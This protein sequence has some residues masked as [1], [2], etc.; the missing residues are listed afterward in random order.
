MKESKAPN[1]ALVA[2][3]FIILLGLA[4]IALYVAWLPFVPWWQEQVAR[5]T[6]IALAWTGVHARLIT[7]PFVGLSVQGKSIEISFVCLGIVEW[8]LLVSAILASRGFEWK[9]RAKGIVYGTVALFAFNEFR[10][11]FTIHTIL[12][13][14]IEFSE[15]VHG[16]L[17]R[18][19]LFVVLAGFYWAWVKS[20]EKP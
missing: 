9:H 17:F 18:A 16:V 19:F 11:V 7:E 5:F 12:N 1:K 3:A 2:S 20:A 15:A 13:S 6:Q 14:S 4:F 8:A 10:I